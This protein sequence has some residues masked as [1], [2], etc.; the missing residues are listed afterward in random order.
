M[1][2]VHE[3]AKA[4]QFLDHLTSE[5]AQTRVGRLAAA[6]ANEIPPLI[7]EL[8]DSNPEAVEEGQQFQAVFEYQRVLEPKDQAGQSA[9]FALLQIPHGFDDSRSIPGVC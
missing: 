6:I 4:V 7:C 5:R 8:Y 3:H 1:T 2:Q 9:S